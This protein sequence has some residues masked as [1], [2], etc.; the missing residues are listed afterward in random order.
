MLNSVTRSK[1]FEVFEVPESALYPFFENRFWKFGPDFRFTKPKEAG[2]IYVSRGFGI[3]N[4]YENPTRR[5]GCASKTDA[6]K[7]QFFKVPSKYLVSRYLLRTLDELLRSRQRDVRM[8]W[9]FPDLIDNPKKHDPQ[10]F[11]SKKCV[12]EEKVFL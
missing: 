10:F 5:W 7:S 11:V 8:S 6:K 12:F 9:N 2:N 4:F 1:N 3:H